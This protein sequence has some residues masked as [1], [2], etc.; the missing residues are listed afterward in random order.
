[1]RLVSLGFASVS[2]LDTTLEKDKIYMNYYKTLLKAEDKAEKQ[3]V[4]AWEGQKL[5][6]WAKILYL[7][8]LPSIKVPSLKFLKKK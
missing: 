7:L 1:M 4:G 5:S 3:G 2:V 8:N 6:L